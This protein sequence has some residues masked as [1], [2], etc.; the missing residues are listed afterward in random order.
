MVVD[1]LVSVE[2]VLA[3][4]KVVQANERENADLFWAIRGMLYKSSSY[5][6]GGGNFGVVTEFVYKAYPHEYPVYSGLLVYTTDQLETFVDTFNRWFE[7]PNG[8]NPKTALFIAISRPPPRY[9][10]AIAA[11]PFYDGPEEEG[12]HIFKPFF[13]IFPV[14]DLTG[15]L[16]Y[17][18]Q[19]PPLT[20]ALTV[21]WHGQLLSSSRLPPLS[22]GRCFPSNNCP[23]PQSG[24]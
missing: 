19:A 18:E 14:T 24:A 9:A 16:P 4:G 11:L 21:E 23:N 13:D 8:R 10:P 15:E 3:S 12:R 6:G 17:V 1:N 20:I 5:L 22:Q 7:S 2:M